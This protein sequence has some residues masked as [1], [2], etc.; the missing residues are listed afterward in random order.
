MGNDPIFKSYW[1]QVLALA[2]DNLKKSNK[3]LKQLKTY[4][5]DNIACEWTNYCTWILFLIHVYTLVKKFY[6]QHN[7]QKLVTDIF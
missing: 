7:Q 1:E 3:L 5:I 2:W 4:R 6:V